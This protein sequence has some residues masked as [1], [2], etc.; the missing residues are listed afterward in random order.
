MLFKTAGSRVSE[1]DIPLRLTLPSTTKPTR[2]R[3]FV[4]E[5]P[6][7]LALLRRI[8]QIAPSEATVLVLGE[9][10][11]GKEIVARHVHAL[12]QRRD[13]PFVAINCGALTESL[14]ES[15]LFGH[16]RG[17]FTGAN[18]GKAGWFEAAKGGTLFLDEVAELSL[19]S[20]VKLL[21][22]LQEGEIVRLGSRE[23][24]RVDVR[25]IAA[26]NVPLQ[27]A[28]ADGRFRADL[29]YRLNIAPLA[30]LALRD[31][32]GDILP[33]ARHF[34]DV[35]RQKLDLADVSIAHETEPYLLAHTWPGNI[36]EL[37]NV[38]HRALLVCSDG[39][40]TPLDLMLPE[41]LSA[42][43]QRGMPAAP[44][45]ATIS[46]DTS[47]DETLDSV[48]QQLF[49]ANVPNLF[50]FIEERT[51]RGAHEYCGRNQVKTARLLGLSRNVVRARLLE[52]GAITPSVPP[53]PAEQPDM[54]T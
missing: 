29:F 14:V 49:E 9:T 3:A 20:Q 50:Q 38:I 28:V 17:A 30:L 33:L 26:T 42:H 44:V 40:I 10:G 35:Y 41:V 32:R 18:S 47:T 21:R 27:Q 4:S 13:F 37:E 7:S 36:R 19:S 45:V 48:L 1:D 11:T 53:S 54:E 51:I 39:R 34:L 15:E 31:R 52:Y 25:L 5:D 23:P 46:S 6:E 8:Q 22:V 16:E 24:A 43:P 2:A 12:S